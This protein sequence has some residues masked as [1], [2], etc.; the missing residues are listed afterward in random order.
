MIIKVIISRM[1]ACLTPLTI[2]PLSWSTIGLLIL[3]IGFS[4]GLDIMLSNLSLRYISV[5]NY[6][7]LKST[8][9]LWTYI[10]A[11]MIGVST[12]QV[13]SFLSVITISAGLAMA[14]LK[15]TDLNLIGAIFV[16]AASAA[17]GLRWALLQMLILKDPISKTFFGSVYR[18]S[19]AA[20]LGV[21]PVALIVDLPQL[22]ESTFVSDE[23]A[24]A[25]AILI[26]VCSG[27]MAFLLVTVEVRIVQL[28]SSV[29]LS[30]LGQVKELLQIVLAI[31]IFGDSLSSKL[32]VPFADC[33][34]FPSNQ[35]VR[36]WVGL[37]RSACLQ[38][39]SLLS[40]R[41]YG[42]RGA[43]VRSCR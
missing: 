26:M 34:Y 7:L 42:G 29:T 4:T 23:T 25:L 11:L 31:I 17:A 30:V 3:P 22:T 32:L 43:V 20:V 13:R 8:V 19:P 21:V 28:T 2:P 18:F 24:L 1:W 6:T 40:P 12:F 38:D 35:R 39:V 9:L 10:W 33:F 41:P 15:S 14:I 37:N 27:F 5:T 16:L 36:H